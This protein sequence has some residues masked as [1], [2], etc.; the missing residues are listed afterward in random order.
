MCTLLLRG[1]GGHKSI[2]C[3][4]MLGAGTNK[5]HLCEPKFRRPEHYHFTITHSNQ[6]VKFFH[7]MIFAKIG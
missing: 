5:H 6:Q 3:T 2:I 7:S 4:T 1:H